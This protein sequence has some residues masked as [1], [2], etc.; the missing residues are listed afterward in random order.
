MNQARP[1]RADAARNRQRILAAARAYISA[2]GPEAG[3]EEIAQAAGVAVGTLYRHFPRKADLVSAVIDE[4]VEQVADD[5]QAALARAR[6]GGS[7]G[8]EVTGFLCRVMESMARNHGVKTAAASLGAGVAGERPGESRA[9]TALASLLD[10]ARA[11]G[12]VR[13]DVTVADIYLLMATAPVDQPRPVRQ[14]WLELILPGLT[15]GS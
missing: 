14:R 10:M 5:A 9:A 3:M 8:G 12:Q 2:R 11:G 1:L 13:A 4:H 15:A 6:A 7:A